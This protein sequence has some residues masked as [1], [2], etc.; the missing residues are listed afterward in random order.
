MSPE[1]LASNEP[2]WVDLESL[3]N[4][5]A[6]RDLPI[7]TRPL[8]RADLAASFLLSCESRPEIAALPAAR[9]VA[10]ELSREIEALG[11]TPAS[12]APAP[13]FQAEEGG[14]RLRVSSALAAFAHVTKDEGHFDEGTRIGA[15]FRVDLGP[16]AFAST[17][18]GVERLLDATN[19]GDAIVKGT[20]WYFN[21]DS[22]G[23]FVRSDFADFALAL[24]RHRW[25]PGSAGTLLLSDAAPSFP[26]F[27]FARTFGARARFTAI[28]ASLHAPEGRWFSAHRLEFALAPG[29]HLGLHES[30]AYFSDGVD[31]LYAVNLVPYTIV[32]RI[33]DRT[34]TTGAPIGEHRNNLMVG[35]DL[36]WRIADGWRIDGEFLLD[37]ISTETSSIPH[38]IGIQAGASWAGMLAGRAADARLEATKVYQDT[39]AVYYGANFLQD[40]VPLGFARGPDVEFLRGTLDTDVTTDIRVGLGLDAERHGEGKPGDFW[41]PDAGVSQN[42][43]STLTGVVTR[44]LFPHARIRAAWR[45]ALD[46][47]ARAGVKQIENADHVAGRDETGF[48]GDLA[49]RWEW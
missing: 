5:G 38:R 6:L 23:L 46:A 22:A 1:V 40:D 11:G 14:A 20:E 41:D 24:D 3:W 21:T 48:F 28:T 26:Q 12:R 36:E 16:R 43:G 42:S 49:L 25:G 44:T 35:A 31:L 47:T 2:I 33:L 4:R 39:Y 30:A 27:A 29:L 9:R 37:E 34:S 13:V 17:D 18:V 45:G 32:Q 19:L 15:I 10:R 8:P 7:F